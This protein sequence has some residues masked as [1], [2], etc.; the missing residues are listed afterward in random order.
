VKLLFSE[1][2]IISRN[3][4]PI[5]VRILEA[6][7]KKNSAG[8][9]GYPDTLQLYMSRRTLKGSFSR[10]FNQRINTLA[11]SAVHTRHIELHKAVSTFRTREEMTATLERKTHK[12]ARNG[13]SD[14]NGN[15][16][17]YSQKSTKWPPPGTSTTA[18]EPAAS[19]LNGRRP[20]RMVSQTLG[21]EQSAGTVRTR[22]G[23]GGTGMVKSP[24]ELWLV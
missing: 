9:H 15:G 20:K 2:R 1:F 8:I 4:I 3:L 21:R 13:H 23:G 12:M 16:H 11:A 14:I 10:N 17:H 24:T 5:S 19:H 6:G 18:V 7:T 22:N